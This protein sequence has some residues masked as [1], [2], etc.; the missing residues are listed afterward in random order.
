MYIMVKL[1][2]GW[3]KGLAVLAGGLAS[4]VASDSIMAQSDINAESQQTS[5]THATMQT[6][7][8]KPSIE[9]KIYNHLSDGNQP[10]NSLFWRVS[11]GNGIRDIIFE[12]RDKSGNIKDKR[13]IIKDS[14]NYEVLW[15][16][17]V[18]FRVVDTSDY[19][20]DFP[21]TGNYTLGVRFYG[22]NNVYTK[23]ITA[24]EILGSQESPNPWSFVLAAGAGLGIG[25][26]SVL[27]NKYIKRK[28]ANENNC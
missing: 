28:R 18:D 21:M 5:T 9:F 27:I 15:G 23:A 10:Y 20:K 22:D 16:H 19:I 6:E 14:G 8:S 25:A 24:P 4:I 17:K 1:M 11:S 13:V 26:F 7:N 3:R 12:A 2:K